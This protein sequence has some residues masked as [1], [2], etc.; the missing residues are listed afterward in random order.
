VRI[1]ALKIKTKFLHSIQNIVSFQTS[2]QEIV[3]K[4]FSLK[5][6]RLTRRDFAVCSR[7]AS[8]SRLAGFTLVEVT[9][10]IGIISFAFVTMFGLLPVGLNV[11]RQAMDTTIE[12]QIVQQMKTQALQTD[13]SMLDSLNN[14][15]AQYFDDQGK[16]VAAN[17]SVFTAKYAAV[18]ADTKLP[19][20]SVTRSLKTI[21]ITVSNTKG[22]SETTGS[23]APKKFTILIPDNGL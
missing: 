23:R 15:D 3:M 6:E 21:A 8:R 13:F 16:E 2:L 20:G 7:R 9:L 10:A 18:S 4:I 1:I 11:S 12:A 14:V 22:T 5:T 19:D 17:V